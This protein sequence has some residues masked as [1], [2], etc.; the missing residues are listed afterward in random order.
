[1]LDKHKILDQLARRKEYYN[2]CKAKTPLKFKEVYSE[3]LYILSKKEEAFFDQY[4]DKKCYAIINNLCSP[5][6]KVMRVKVKQ[7]NTVYL[8]DFDTFE[9]EE[10]TLSPYQKAVERVMDKE[11]IEDMYNYRIFELILQGY[12]LR[13]IRKLT[14]DQLP[15]NELVRV[16]KLFKEKIKKEYQLWCNQ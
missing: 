13:A 2:F 5:M 9:N 14:K 16:K 15:Y 12:S 4:I 8:E 3:F 1:M 10:A 11:K 7:A 6:S